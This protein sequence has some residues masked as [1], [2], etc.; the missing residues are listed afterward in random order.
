MNFDYNDIELYLN[1]ELNAEDARAFEQQMQA[2]EALQKKVQDY[3]QL[4]A[5]IQKYTDAEASLP[6]LK[7]I[8]EPL[9][10]QHFAGKHQQAGVFTLKRVSY[11]LAA[12]A[13]IALIFFLTLPGISPDGYRVDDMP[14]AIV[15]GNENTRTKAAQLFNAKHYEEAALALQQLKQTLP[16]DAEIDFYLGISF[17]KTEKYQEALPLFET[18]ISGVSAYK[19]DAVFFAALS[20]YHLQQKD[21]AKQYA[22]QVKNGSRYDKEAK[23]ILKKMN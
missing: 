5:T 22:E 1:G 19:E 20:A 2:D 8:L 21:K 11:V 6:P 13:S 17:L 9:T 12:A 23:A 18:L 4:Q 15:R 16:A 10:Q 14:G 3:Q 7:A